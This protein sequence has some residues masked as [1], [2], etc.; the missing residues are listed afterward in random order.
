[1]Y[2]CTT[3]LA[4]LAFAGF[5]NGHARMT[6]P[7]PRV[8]GPKQVE[9]CGALVTAVLESDLAGPIENAVDS[10]DA[11]YNCNAYLCRGYQYE[12]NTSNVMALT[13]GDVI[14]CHIDLVAGH[15]PG[16][17]NVSVVDLAANKIIGD[18]LIYW[19]DWPDSTSGP[20]RNDTDFNVTIPDGLGSACD[21]G[22]QCA[23]QWYWWSDSNDQTYESCLDFYI[24]S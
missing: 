17:S 1:M 6:T 14:P 15:H 11:N 18:E 10:A 23:I 19:A 21:E 7:Q 22:G 13:A 8:T 4:A 5:V 2:T 9:L 3:G 12:D 24:A 20:P 16:W